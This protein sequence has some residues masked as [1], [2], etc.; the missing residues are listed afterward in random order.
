MIIFIK[1]LDKNGCG[2]FN[3]GTGKGYTVKQVYDVAIE[4]LKMK[5]NFVYKSNRPGDPDKL[6]TTNKL[7][8][9]KLR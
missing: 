8:K 4:T 9:S 2:T 1:Y 7:A 3:L 6:L 5:P